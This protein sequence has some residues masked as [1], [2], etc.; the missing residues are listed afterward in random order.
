ME[1]AIRSAYFLLTGKE[2]KEL[3]VQEMRGLD[4]IKEAKS[5]SAISRLA[6]RWPA[7]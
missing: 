3:K 5:R 7:A 6:W 1:A 2:L 4:G